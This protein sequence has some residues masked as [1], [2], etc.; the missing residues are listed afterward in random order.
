MQPCVPGAMQHQGFQF[1]WSP[2]LDVTWVHTTGLQQGWGL[3]EGAREVM[4]QEGG[5]WAGE[6]S[7]AL[8]QHF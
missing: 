3:T 2:G 1:P 8:M 4:G 7:T 5:S 6:E